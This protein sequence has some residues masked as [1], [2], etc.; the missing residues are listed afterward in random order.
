MNIVIPKT[1]DKCT[2]ELYL[3]LEYNDDII[4]NK[5]QYWFDTAQSFSSVISGKTGVLIPINSMSIARG[6]YDSNYRNG[7]VVIIIT[8]ISK[9]YDDDRF[10]DAIK[11]YIKLLIAALKC[12]ADFYISKEQVYSYAD[13]K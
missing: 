3:D 9:L 4:K 5:S 10:K 11:D 7:Q 6:S 12:S 2:I 1:M 8:S 13:S